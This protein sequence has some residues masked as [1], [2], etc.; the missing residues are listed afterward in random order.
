MFYR[1]QNPVGQPLNEQ[2]VQCVMKQQILCVSAAT[3]RSHQHHEGK[4]SALTML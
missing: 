1:F 3:E 4:L 2:Q